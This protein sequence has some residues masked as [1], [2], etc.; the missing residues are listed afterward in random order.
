[1]TRQNPKPPLNWEVRHNVP[2]IPRD[3]FVRA[4]D[5]RERRP[6]DVF[7]PLAW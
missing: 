3:L 6:M 2:A 4:Q 7:A 5:R 1:V